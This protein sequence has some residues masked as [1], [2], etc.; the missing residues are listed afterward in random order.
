MTPENA[1]PIAF[2]AGA[3]GYTGSHLVEILRERGWT[4]HAHVR[5]DSTALADWTARF[6]ALGAVVDTTPWE[7][8]ALQADLAQIQPTHV[9]ALLGTTRARAKR[10]SGAIADTYEAVDYGL[11][12]MLR[13]CTE[14]AA[15]HARFVYLSSLGVRQGTSNAYLAARARLEGELRAGA[16]DWVIIRPA[17]IAGAD[18][19]ENRV[20]ETVARFAVGGALSL[21]G[22]V[23]P[24]AAR[25]WKTRDGRTLATGIADAAIKAPARTELDG[26]A[27][28]ALQED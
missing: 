4:V 15:P 16:L 1:S 27:L 23:A 24:R 6:E 5:P 10:G 13:R 14:A 20:N 26:D 19:P 22:L 18:R 17:L 7:E 12:A 28:D 11:S 25:A 8:H 9:F 21:V 2:I 3:T